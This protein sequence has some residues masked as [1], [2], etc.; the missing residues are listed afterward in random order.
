[1]AFEKVTYVDG[2][3]V[4]GAKNL[5]DIQDEFD[6]KLDIDFGTANA[7]KFLTVGNDGKV[8]AVS[9]PSAQGVSF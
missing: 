8:T 3:T 5:N 7:G 6:N 9:L 4:I 1:M 2:V